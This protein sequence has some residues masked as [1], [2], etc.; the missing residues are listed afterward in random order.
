[1]WVAI[2]GYGP[3]S[4]RAAFGDDAAAAGGLVRR[5]GDGCPL[6]SGDA[7][8]DPLTGLVAA[9]FALAGVRAGGSWRA[10]V[11]LADVAAFAAALPAMRDERDGVHRTDS[12]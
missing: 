9:V 7:L 2:T 4:N 5:A 3:Q 11:A 10:D 12:S 6:F 1:V 8:A